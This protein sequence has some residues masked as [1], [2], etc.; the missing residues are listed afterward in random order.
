MISGAVLN[1]VL[2]PIF[3]FDWGL[4]LGV[5]GAS[6]ATAISQFITFLIM[7]WFYAS[8]RSVIKLKTKAFQPSW[9]FI[10]AVAA[11]GIPTAVIQICLSIV[12]I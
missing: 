12:Y 11:I 6:L 10:K 1:I 3:M 9:N 4:N 2:D 7:V 5:E 8:G